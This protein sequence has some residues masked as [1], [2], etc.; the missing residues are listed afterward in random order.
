M[1]CAS[2]CS[3][4]RAFQLLPRPE[5]RHATISS[6]MGSTVVK[7]AV[8]FVLAALTIHAYLALA[9]LAPPWFDRITD[10]TM[11]FLAGL[12]Y[13]REP[14]PAAQSSADPSGDSSA[15][16]FQAQP[17]ADAAQSEGVATTA[18]F[19]YGDHPKPVKIVIEKINVSAD[20]VVPTSTDVAVLDE[21][22]LEGVVYY[23]GSGRLGAP[24]NMFLF[25][26]SS[27]LPYIQNE[28]F[29]LFNGLRDLTLEDRI[30][31]Y[32]QDRA[33]VY[34]VSAVKAVSKE[35]AWVDFSD[36]KESL[37]TLS[38]CNTFGKKQDRVV[39]EAVHVDTL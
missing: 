7:S 3:V 39:V 28:N 12:A 21:A 24:G 17:G 27:W 26:H 1:T 35:R 15:A 8:L 33:Y 36:A 32:S 38:S 13:E 37:L 4:E 2:A 34:E 18:P 31:V 23:P 20:I 11:Y 22:L 25:A 5:R 9:G 16:R 30:V 10:K 29:A 14:S 6:A 19:V